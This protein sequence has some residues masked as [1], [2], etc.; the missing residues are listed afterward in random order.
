MMTSKKIEMRRAFLE[1][2]SSGPKSYFRSEGAVVWAVGTVLII[3]AGALALSDVTLS[4][5][6]LFLLA[7]IAL[8]LAAACT[9]LKD[10][11]NCIECK[12]RKIDWD[13]DDCEDCKDGKKLRTERFDSGDFDGFDDC[14]DCEDCKIRRDCENMPK[15]P[16]GLREY[17][18]E[19]NA[20]NIV[21]RG[22]SLLDNQ[23]VG[24]LVKLY[25][26]VKPPKVK[27]STS[28]DPL[29]E[30]V[31]RTKKDLK[32]LYKICT[33]TLSPSHIRI[34]SETERAKLYMAL[35]SYQS[36]GPAF[37]ARYPGAPP[38][39]V[40][41]QHLQVKE[42]EFSS[43]DED[44]SGYDDDMNKPVDIECVFQDGEAQI[45]ARRVK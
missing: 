28:E 41:I 11:K 5:G 43:S 18:T 40:Q 1:K 26:T 10:C 6:Y 14:G 27:E 22:S 12:E 15:V 2:Y 29:R 33:A 23:H 45:W 38:E 16:L 32:R 42:L 39:D 17:K 4:I 13:Y 24:Y 3:G 9:F 8:I 34:E 37:S 44:S 30:G 19:S 25:D 20:T 21:H 7:F 31:I 36:R 35:E